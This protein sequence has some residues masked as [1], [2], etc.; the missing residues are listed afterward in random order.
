VIFIGIIKT[1]KEIALLKKS[2]EISNSC[3]PI[4]EASLKEEKITEK[5]IVRR[6][7]KKLKSQDATFSFIPIVACGKRS[8]RIHAMPRSTNKIISGIGMIDFG[9]CYKGYRTDV[10]VPFIKGKISKRERRIVD[11]VVK[12]Y[13]V[14]VR[15]IRIGMPC[16]KLFEKVDNFLRKRGFRMG[17]SLGHGLGL[18]IHELPYIGKPRKRIDVSKK[19]YEKMRKRWE[20]LSK[21]TFQNNMVF[22]IEPG[23]YVKSVGGSRL[24]ND[25]LIENKRIKILTNAKLIRV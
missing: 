14:G 2:A 6:M 17:H 5:E 24:E 9:A 21:I 22:T 19:I 1:Q 12:A 4:I 7:R 15:S 10:T 23:V 16:W 11:S 13:N 8:A 20:K 18:K 25:I 3:L